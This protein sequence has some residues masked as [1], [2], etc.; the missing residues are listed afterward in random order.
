MCEKHKQKTSSDYNK[1]RGSASKNGYD[2]T[3]EKIRLIALKRDQYICQECLEKGD[4]IVP[5]NH[6]DHAIPFKGKDDPLRLDLSNLRSLCQPCHS[7]KTVKHDGG[8]GRPRTPV[9]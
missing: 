1:F 4:R 2:R 9:M 3:W 7:R 5:A 6:V 8:F